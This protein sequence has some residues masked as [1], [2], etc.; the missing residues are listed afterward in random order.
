MTIYTLGFTGKTAEQFFGLI[1][2]HKIKR[3]FDI[4]LHNSSQLAGFTKKENLSWLLGELCHCEYIHDLNLAPDWELFD[5]IKKNRIT[6][7]EYERRYLAL[8]GS[9]KIE[10]TLE[11]S[12]FARPT[13]LLCSEP[14]AE[15][16]H[17]RLL[18]EYLQRHWSDVTA[19]H[20]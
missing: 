20:L 2:R 5:D 18:I 16:C 11:E 3:L 9:R 4:R 15:N 7:R 12:S 8:I 1:R 17:R 19:V 13:V 6:W 10:Q 14:T